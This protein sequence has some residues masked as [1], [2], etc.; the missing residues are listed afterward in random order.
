MPAGCPVWPFT[1][2]TD[3]W[4]HI[5]VFGGCK[6]LAQRLSAQPWWGSAGKPTSLFPRHWSC[7]WAAYSTGNCLSGH[8]WAREEEAGA[9]REQVPAYLKRWGREIK[10]EL[11]HLAGNGRGALHMCSCQR[12]VEEP[13]RHSSCV[14]KQAHAYLCLKNVEARLQ[15]NRKCSDKSC[16]SMIPTS[17]KLIGQRRRSWERGSSPGD[18]VEM[19]QLPEGNSAK[20]AGRCWGRSRDAFQSGSTSAKVMQMGRDKKPKTLRSEETLRNL[21]KDLTKD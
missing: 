3:I 7:T 5:S 12:G 19:C 20:A 17:R 21:E 1:A 6:S 18:V 2:Q 9:G 15:R 4:S 10:Q 13:P 11:D 8:G 16:A 14:C